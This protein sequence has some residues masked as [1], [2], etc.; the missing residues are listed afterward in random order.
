MIFLCSAHLGPDFSTVFA[1]IYSNICQAQRPCLLYFL[2]A[3]LLVLELCI[4]EAAVD[5]ACGK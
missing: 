1:L 3:Y 5:M 4:W 2:I